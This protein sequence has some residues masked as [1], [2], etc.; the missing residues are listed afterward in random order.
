ML[1]YADDFLD[2]AGLDAQFFEVRQIVCRDIV[3]DA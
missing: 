3:T 2:A 1:D